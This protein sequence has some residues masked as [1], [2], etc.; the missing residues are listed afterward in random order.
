VKKT[1]R[2]T[3]VKNIVDLLERHSSRKVSRAMAEYLLKNRRTSELQ[4]ILRDVSL[5]RSRYKNI[6]EVSAITARPLAKNHESAVVSGVKRMYPKARKVIVNNKVDESLIGGVRLEFSDK[7]VD[8]SVEG[9][10]A[11]LRE[12]IS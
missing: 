9:Q 8:A 5:A 3:L 2:A 4:S 11:R 7:Q 10:V 12:L 1:S 6:V